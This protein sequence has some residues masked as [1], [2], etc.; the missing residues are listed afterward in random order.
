MWFIIDAEGNRKEAFQGKRSALAHLAEYGEG[1]SIIEVASCPLQK[2]RKDKELT[3]EALAKESGASLRIIQA[4]ECGYR[5]INSCRVD[6][7]HK[8]A[9]VLDCKI[10]DLL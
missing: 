10:E 7:A 6:I 1:Y 8:L 9:T 3:Q 2:L 5:D 4:I